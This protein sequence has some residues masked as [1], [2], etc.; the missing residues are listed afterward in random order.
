[1]RFLT[2]HYCT[3]HCTA[4][5][6]TAHTYSVLLH[7]RNARHQHSVVPEARCRSAVS[8]LPAAFEHR[9][10]SQTSRGPHFL[11]STLRVCILLLFAQAGHTTRPQYDGGGLVRG[12][13]L[14]CIKAR[15]AAG[16][17]RRRRPMR[18]HLFHLDFWWAG[19]GGGAAGLAE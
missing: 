6:C 14:R 1:M 19:S 5:Y 18:W 9:Q 4:L 12:R 2:L 16:R 3:V 13:G 15:P 10:P 8:L 17:H 7:T 11:H